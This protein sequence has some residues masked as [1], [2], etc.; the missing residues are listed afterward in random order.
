MKLSK[1]I[2]EIVLS[3]GIVLIAL[4]LFLPVQEY[5]LYQDGSR[6]NHKILEDNSNIAAYEKS[7]VISKTLFQSL[8]IAVLTGGFVLVYNLGRK[9]MP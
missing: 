2:R 9:Q 6:V 4:R 1:N 3:L 8:G 5:Q 7:V